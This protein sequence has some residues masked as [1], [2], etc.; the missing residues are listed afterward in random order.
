VGDAAFDDNRTVS[1]TQAEIVQ[2]VDLQRK[3]R[4]ELGSADADLFD[5]DWLEHH[6]LAVQ[7][8]QDLDTLAFSFVV[9]PRG[10]HRAR[11]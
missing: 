8:T 10:G 7:L 2:R 5:R 1:K 6:D 3:H 9:V 11:L 4:L